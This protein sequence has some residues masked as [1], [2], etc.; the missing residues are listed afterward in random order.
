MKSITVQSDWL[1]LAPAPVLF[2]IT[3][4]LPVTCIALHCLDLIPLA[5]GGLFL[6]LPSLWISMLY[7]IHDERI[8]QLV[9]H[10]WISGI[11]AV[12]FYDLSRIPFVYLGWDDFIP[13]IST[14]L[15]PSG[16]RSALVG[17]TWRYI[18]NGGGLGISF[19]M[20]GEL[21]N[22]RKNPV[23]SGVTF[24]MF[25]FAGLLSLLVFYPQSQ[26]LMFE[27]TPVAFFGGLTGHIVYGWVV[28]RMY[29]VLQLS[30]RK[31]KVQTKSQQRF[32]W[33][34]Q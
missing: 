19:F 32:A 13:N 16:E 9:F 4:I 25:V 17:Y 27:I 6:V 5:Y 12:T 15:M 20:L 7:A 34:L 11:V 14:W 30:K 33:L 2:F 18:G 21:L 1:R 23:G 22:M 8:M 3:G 29:R 31:I 24:G 26:K 28:G 10:G